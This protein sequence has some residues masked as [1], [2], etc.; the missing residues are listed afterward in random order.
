[1]GD[2]DELGGLRHLIQHGDEPFHVGVIQG[3]VHLVQQAEGAGPGGEEGEQEGQGRQSAL[4]AREQR[5][6]RGPLARD[7]EE[8]LD[9]RLL[10][11]F[12]LGRL[13]QAKL[14]ASPADQAAPVVVEVLVHHDQGRI[15]E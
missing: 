11:L 10:V 12:A 4:A 14:R 13:H 9:A 15:E 8:H 5:Q 3:G 1:M 2:D 7:L 6:D